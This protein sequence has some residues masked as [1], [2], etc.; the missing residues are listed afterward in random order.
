MEFE[1]DPRKA[2]SNLKKH[3]DSFTEAA[4]DDL[5]PSYDLTSLKGGVRGKYVKRFQAW[6]KP[7]LLSWN[8]EPT[9]PDDQHS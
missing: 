5:R 7:V 2:E 9:F 8:V 1:W 4:A 6:T 3:G